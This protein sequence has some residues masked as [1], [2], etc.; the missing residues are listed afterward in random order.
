MVIIEAAGPQ[1]GKQHT[2]PHK[3]NKEK[4]S[5]VTAFDSKLTNQNND[6]RSGAV[7]IKMPANHFATGEWEV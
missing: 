1:M 3:T 5:F 6:D 4:R 2:S 7:V